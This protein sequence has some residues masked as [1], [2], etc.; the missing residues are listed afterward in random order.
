MFKETRQ[1]MSAL[2][3]MISACHNIS[4]A[5]ACDKCPLHYTECFESAT[6]ADVCNEVPMGS[7]DDMLALS[8]D[9]QDYISEQDYIADLADRERKEIE[10]GY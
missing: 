5:G 6:F 9:V 2:E 3:L 7:I 10:Y 8:D 4:E 1:I